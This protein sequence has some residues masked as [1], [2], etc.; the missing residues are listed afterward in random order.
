[1]QDGLRQVARSPRDE[2]ERTRSAQEVGQ[3][4]GFTLDISTEGEVQKLPAHLQRQ[5]LLI[6]REILRFAQNDITNEHDY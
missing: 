6:M 5:V 1:M 4:S 2:H 3:S